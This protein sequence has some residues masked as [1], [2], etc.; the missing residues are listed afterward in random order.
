[1]PSTAWWSAAG[2]G[3][4]PI[5]GRPKRRVCLTT[6]RQSR[7]VLT[8][9]TVARL[10]Y[11]GCSVKMRSSRFSRS[12]SS[13][14]VGRADKGSCCARSRAACI[15]GLRT[16]PRSA[17]SSPASQQ[18]GDGGL[19]SKKN[20]FDLQLAD[21]TV[22]IVDELLRVV[23]R[24]RLVAT[25]FISSC[26]QVLIIVGWTPNSDDSCDEVFVTSGLCPRRARL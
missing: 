14:D 7:L 15:A 26:F 3:T 12:N 20:A 23:D 10:P 4:R 18:S 22:Q 17:R 8:Q 11:T 21:L 24:R 16:V 2:Y 25:R 6:S 9:L 19:P 13:A 1:L 5:E